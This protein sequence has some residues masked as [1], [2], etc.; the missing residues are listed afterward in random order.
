MQLSR[1]EG[2]DHFFGCLATLMSNMIRDLV[3]KSIHDIVH[4][5]EL[6]RQVLK[7]SVNRL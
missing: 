6:Y 5:L 4:F 3:R 7:S 1:M 2:M